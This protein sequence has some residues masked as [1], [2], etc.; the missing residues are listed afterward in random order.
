M[1]NGHSGRKFHAALCLERALR[2]VLVVLVDAMCELL[3][4]TSSVT[5]E[6]EHHQNIL[7]AFLDLCTRCFHLGDSLEAYLLEEESGR[8][9]LS[10]YFVLVC[11]CLEYPSDYA[12]FG[13]GRGPSLGWTTCV[14][15]PEMTLCA[16]GC[17]LGPPGLIGRLSLP[18]GRPRA[19]SADRACTRPRF[20]FT[21]HACT[22]I[23]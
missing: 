18:T 10:Y 23:L 4:A 11:L 17:L 9:G 5:D 12:D 20:H 22:H 21:E 7:N 8:D 3:E 19:A 1:G 13:T 6:E 15:P 16:A 2:A 14:F